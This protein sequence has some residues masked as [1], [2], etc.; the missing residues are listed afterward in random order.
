MNQEDAAK[1]HLKAAEALFK[2]MSMDYWLEETAKIE[3]WVQNEAG[4]D[5][6]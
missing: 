2:Q 1:T 6:G 4:S 5:E 3:A